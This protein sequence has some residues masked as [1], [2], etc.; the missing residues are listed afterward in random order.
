MGTGGG[1]ASAGTTA[2][3]GAQS[4]ME[5]EAGRVTTATE[6]TPPPR[7]EARQVPGDLGESGTLPT[8]R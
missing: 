7:R 4:A 2:A 8:R 5:T 3:T 1:A 6:A